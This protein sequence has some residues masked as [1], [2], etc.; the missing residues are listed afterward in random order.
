MAG[1]GCGG[2][3]E[4]VRK[5]FKILVRGNNYLF[6]Q[7]DVA[8]GPRK[9]GFYKTVFVEAGN[10]EEAEAVAVDILKNDSKLL[11]ACK[12]GKADPPNISI[13]STDEILSFENCLLPRT[14]LVLYVEE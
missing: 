11:E 6:Q 4:I 8:D 12:N 13:E 9:H 14:A 1:D 10:S 5:K 2:E 7:L 3:K